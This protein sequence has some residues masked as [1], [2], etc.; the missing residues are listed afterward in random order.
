[1]SEPRRDRAGM[2][3]RPVM[4]E[5]FR[6]ELRSRLLTEAS[7]VLARGGRTS[8][9]SHTWLRPAFAAAAAFII[10]VGGATT[11][12]GSSLPG[13]PLYGLKRTTEDVQV[14]LTFDDVARMALLSELTDRRLDDLAKIAAQHPAAAPTAT[15][16]YAD[17][18]E[19]FNDAVDKLRSDDSDDKRAAAQAVAEAAR[20]KHRAV[21]DAVRSRLSGERRDDLD[22][23]IEREQE[24]ENATPT[25]VPGG[26]RGDGKGEPTPRPANPTRVTPR[27]TQ[28]ATATPHATEKDR[29]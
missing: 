2:L 16:E 11:A 18:V 1:M 10:V 24:R 6:S 23:V 14:L 9:L 13:D 17:A 4:R 25:E 27:P 12:S 21:L 15:S 26:D 19:R 20:E 8:W 5:A 29:D 28:R 3:E 7:V 22:R